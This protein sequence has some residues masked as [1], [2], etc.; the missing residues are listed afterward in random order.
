[1]TDKPQAGKIN[2][3]NIKVRL[4]ELRPW[5]DNPKFS[6]KAQAQ[7]ILDSFKKFGQVQTVAVSPELD[8]YDGHQRLS[9]LLTIHGDDYE[10]DARQS[11]RLLT[12]KERRE[13]VITLHTSAMGSYNWNM[14]SGWDARELKEWGMDRTKLDE[15][16]IDALNL[17]DLLN[18]EVD[19]R[20]TDV[21]GMAE[22]SI[23]PEMELRLLESYDYIVL[24]FRDSLNWLQ[25]CE[26]FKIGKAAVTIDNKLKKTGVGRAVDGAKFLEYIKQREQK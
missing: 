15:M 5:A 16:N 25:A 10:I 13:L 12:E 14:L 11:N 22:D 19:H 4:G 21:E 1:M 2:W 26:F 3:T 7:R 18:S 8:V 6:T 20:G 23:I 9:A 24:V 17:K